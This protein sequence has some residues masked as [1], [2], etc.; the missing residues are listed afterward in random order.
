MQTNA[1]IVMSNNN[2]T[3]TLTLNDETLIAQLRQPSTGAFFTQ[4]AVAASTDHALASGSENENQ[5]N[6][7][8]TVLTI[9][10]EAGTNTIEVLFK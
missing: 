5:P 4:A 1:T 8:V 7:G 2:Q 9:A 10:C 3:A 6:P